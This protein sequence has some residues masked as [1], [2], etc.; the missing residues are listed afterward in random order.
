[1]N[2]GPLIGGNLAHVVNLFS[3]QRFHVTLNKIDF[4]RN[5]EIVFPGSGPRYSHQNFFPDGPWASP[6]NERKNLAPTREFGENGVQIFLGGAP[7]GPG[8]NIVGVA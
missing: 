1:M 8:G 5:F 2:F 6:F 4:P 7:R 3:E